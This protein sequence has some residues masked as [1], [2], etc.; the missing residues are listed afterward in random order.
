MEVLLTPR[1]AEGLTRD[2][3]MIPSSYDAILQGQVVGDHFRNLPKAQ[4]YC[5]RLWTNDE[6]T[7]LMLR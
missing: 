6:Q 1:D 2:I 3:R 7:F 4:V 5:V